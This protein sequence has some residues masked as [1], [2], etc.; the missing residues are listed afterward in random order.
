MHDSEL[1]VRAKAQ[2]R[3]YELLPV[4]ALAGDFPRPFVD[5]YAHWLRTDTDFIE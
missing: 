5:D 3:V 1:I 4:H 2:G